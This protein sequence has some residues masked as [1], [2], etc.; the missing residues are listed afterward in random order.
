MADNTHK[1]EKALPPGF[2]DPAVLDNSDCETNDTNCYL[3][4]ELSWLEFNL[5]VLMEARDRSVP[6]LERLNFLSIYYS[7]L[8]EFFMVRVGS[9]SYRN[10]LLP[11]STDIK[12]G[13]NASTAL[14]KIL[15]TVEKQQLQA[16]AVYKNLV[17]DLSLAG[18]DVL[19]FRRIS[20]V[21]EAMARKFFA[22]LRPLLSPRIVNSQHP[23]PYV[24]NQEDYVCALVGKGDDV[25]LAMVPLNGLP[26]FKV[27]E[28]DGR[29]KVAITGELVANFFPQLF[30][31]QE[32]K[33]VCTIRVIR[34]ADV[35]IEDNLDTDNIDFRHS[36]EKMLKKRKGQQPIVRLYIQGKPSSK[37]VQL[38]QKNLRAPEKNTFISTL[39]T[40][41]SFGK[42]IKKDNLRYTERRPVRTVNL[43]KGEF[44]RY[45][46]KHDL[47]LSFPYQSITPFIEMLYEAA[48]DPD[49]VSIRIT[50][51]RLAASSKLAAALA[52]ASDR[53][54][55]VQCVLELRARFDEQNNIDY[56]DVLEA[57][58]CNV[59]YGL[60]GQKIHSKLCLITRRNGDKISYIT[61]VGT[62]NYN[63][64]TSE[65]YC[66][67]SLITSDAQIG[68][69]AAALFDSLAIGEVPNPGKK[70]WIAPNGYKPRLFELLD[71]EIE[72]GSEGF[73]ALKLNSINDV[74]VMHKL[75]QCSQAGVK[76]ELFIRG[77]CCLRPG[78]P[79]YTDNITVRSVVGR[80]L[81]HSRVFIFGTGD[82]QRIFM[83]SGDL[84]NRNTRRRVEV[85]IEAVSPDIKQQLLEVVDAM[86]NDREK[87][88]LMASDGTYSKE[89]GGKGTSSQE[90]LY[91]YFS[92]QTVDPLPEN[93]SILSGLFRKI[94]KK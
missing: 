38:L 64:V 76:V 25:N 14:K 5:R 41:V 62:G 63:E 52:Y 31:K 32:I 61:Q 49:V 35:F 21:D 83:G 87:G 33:E 27:F 45:L 71:R 36:I 46:E 43:R 6:L 4:R 15:R 22:E 2:F 30:K 79:G 19:N 54:K 7:N 56:S 57:A 48:D 23:M 93:S 50:L 89:P 8:E 81:E 1:D 9:L 86:R 16:A 91:E 75:V 68:M 78:L 94:F 3:D 24:G 11:D 60:P 85:F 84:L 51:Y 53:G 80:Y 72:K 55:D 13:W 34:N 26:K 73:V 20:K 10:A 17:E 40:T 77:I 18:V 66:D 37:F 44:F 39:P 70:L 90:R 65:L 92:R 28:V 29:Q 82:D 69:D 59:C 47:L 42:G 58:G 88:W 67:L 12:T 74:D